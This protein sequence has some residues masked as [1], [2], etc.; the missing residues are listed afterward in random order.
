MCDM[1]G[2]LQALVR[3]FESLDETQERETQERREG[4]ETR[5]ESEEG[6]FQKQKKTGSQEESDPL[7]D[8]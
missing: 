3:T 4:W 2:E 7:H 6:G 5:R 8:L 1:G